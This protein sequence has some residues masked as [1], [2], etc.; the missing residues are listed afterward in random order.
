MKKIK[1]GSEEF[2]KFSHLFASKEERKKRE[3]LCNSC[4]MMSTTLGAKQCQ[5]CG[6]LSGPKVAINNQTCPL[7]KW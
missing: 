2:S 1:E 4:D 3:N 7:E 6:C 5:E